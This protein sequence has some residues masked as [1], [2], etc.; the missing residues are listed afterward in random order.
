MVIAELVEPFVR[1]HP[2]AD[3]WLVNRLSA[4]M[5]DLSTPLIPLFARLKGQQ[6]GARLLQEKGYSSLRFEAG[7]I[8]R[9][10]LTEAPHLRRDAG[11]SDEGFDGELRLDWRG[12]ELHFF[13]RVY[14]GHYGE[15]TVAMSATKSRAALEEFWRELR[16][17][18]RLHDSETIRMWGDG[19]VARGSLTWDDLVIPQAMKAD[20]RCMVES[21]MSAQPKY[22]ELGL[23][24][25]R[26][27]LLGGPPGCGKST[28]IKVIAAQVKASVFVMPIT[29]KTADYQLSRFMDAAAD[30][31]PSV[32][33]IEDLDR[34]VEGVKT[35]ISMSHLLNLLDGI[36]T[37]QKQGVLLISTANHVDRL[38]PALSP[39]RPGR[40][41]RFFNFE[42][43]TSEERA[44]LL[45]IRG[46]GRFSDE[47]M[48][49]IVEESKGYSH[50]LVQELVVSALLKALNSNREATDQDLYDGAKAM[51]EQS[52]A[53]S[54]S[55]GNLSDLP[56]VGFHGGSQI[57][58]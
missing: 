25:R 17:F 18:Q 41:D 11:L 48:L 51:R 49:R 35:E 6:L 5:A 28:A 3:G 9:H 16:I 36:G 46:K 8:P 45:R 38:D 57:G 34:V 40:Y 54:K 29:A 10:V 39:K 32:C 15:E 26:G 56:T 23:P 44:Q 1:D 47:A 55:R 27:L 14:V 42:P 30:A 33:V 24:W 31:A 21:F 4:N 50:A 7:H 20:L 37:G 53:Q 43:P 13:V 58:V 12:D 19:R 22:Q 52:V 2:A